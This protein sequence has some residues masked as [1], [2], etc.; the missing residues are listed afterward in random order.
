MKK[1][2]AILVLGLFLI[3]PSQADD[4]RDFQIE[5]MSVG[6][7][8]LNYMTKTEINDLKEPFTAGSIISHEF[9]YVRI[10]DNSKFETYDFVGV[11]FKPDN[12]KFYVHSIIGDISFNTIEDC[13]KKQNE[14]LKELSNI[15]KNIAKKVGGDIRK[16]KGD[17]SG[18]S[19]IKSYTFYLYDGGGAHIGCYNFSQELD[20][21]QYLSV[22]LG[23]EEYAEFQNRIYD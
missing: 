7:S 16:Y 12:K 3:T 5:G 6:D 14:I 9:Y 21:G 15:F 1:F 22:E 20:G 10:K 17:K 13:Y 11:N 19:T 2:L 23:S 4:I 18:K 8:L